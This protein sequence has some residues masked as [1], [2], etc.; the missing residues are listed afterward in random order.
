MDC[1]R[2][3]KHLMEANGA[4]CRLNHCDIALTTTV[5]LAR[6]LAVDVCCGDMRIWQTCLFL[7]G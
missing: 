7:L 1:R 6:Q 2:A 4:P 3:S 5:T